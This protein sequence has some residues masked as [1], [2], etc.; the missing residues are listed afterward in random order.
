MYDFVMVC[1]LFVVV[2]VVGK[3]YFSI[4][5]VEDGCFFVIFCIEWAC[6]VRNGIGF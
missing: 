5:V 2:E 1:I 3:V 6:E 4:V